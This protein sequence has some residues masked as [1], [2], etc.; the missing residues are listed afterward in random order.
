MQ[1]ADDHLRVI[2]EV[3]VLNASRP[4]R[5]LANEHALEIQLP[6]EAEVVGESTKNRGVTRPA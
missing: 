3:A 4:P 1:T 2:E 5:A 6:P